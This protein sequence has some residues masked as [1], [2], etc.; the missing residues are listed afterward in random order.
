MT[1]ASEAPLT[2]ATLGLG[3]VSAAQAVGIDPVLALAGAAG[4]LWAQFYLPQMQF[5][6]RIGSVLLGSLIASWSAP[7]LAAA[8]PSLPGWPA[9]VTVDM[10]TFPAAVT[11]GLLFHA[12]GGV[13]HHLVLRRGDPDVR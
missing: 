11:I 13:A 2:G 3:I 12:A 6:V 8:L 9:A 5:S 10:V 7:A 1:L 4:A